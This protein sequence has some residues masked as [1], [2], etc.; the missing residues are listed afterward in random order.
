MN[1]RVT[2][3]ASRILKGDIPL[4]KNVYS[5]MSDIEIVL[6]QTHFR[7][8]VIL[9]EE[10]NRLWLNVCPT[11]YANNSFASD[12]CDQLSYLIRCNHDLNLPLYYAGRNFPYRQN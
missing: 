6:D 1:L 7:G 4:G 10:K 12:L 3:R 11:R 2:D 5:A 8:N 9:D